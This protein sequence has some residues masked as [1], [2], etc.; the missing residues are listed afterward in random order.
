MAFQ[1]ING[2]RVWNP[3]PERK[4][5]G[6]RVVE[7]GVHVYRSRLHQELAKLPKK[8]RLER[9]PDT[10]VLRFNPAAPHVKSP[11]GLKQVRLTNLAKQR[12]DILQG[13]DPYSEQNMAK[14]DRLE[15]LVGQVER[16]EIPGNDLPAPEGA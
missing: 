5:E 2:M 7:N 14:L 10:G 8:G 6:K 3:Q 1:I 9:D 11:T 12:Q 16:D 15:R 13:D 4:E